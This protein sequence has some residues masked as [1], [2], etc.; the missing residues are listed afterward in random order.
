MPAITLPPRD[1]K[2]WSYAPSGELIGV[3]WYSK[4]IDPRLS[5][6]KLRLSERLKLL[7]D[8][9]DSAEFDQDARAFMRTNAD[10]TDRWW[11]MIRSTDDATGAMWFTTDTDPSGTWTQETALNFPVKIKDSMDTFLRV[12]GY[13]RLVA[14]QA[15]S[16]DLSMLNNGNAAVLNIS[17][18]TDATPIAI[19]T[20]VAHNLQTGDKVTVA[21]HTTNTNANGT[22]F[23]TRTG[24]S[25]FTL[26]GSTATGGGAG[27][28]TG[29]VTK[30]KWINSWW[31]GT[32]GQTALD[33]NHP[34]IVRRFNKILLIGNANYVHVI[35]PSADGTVTSSNNVAYKRLVFPDNYEVNWI[36]CTPTKA[37]I[38]L[39]DLIGGDAIAAPWNG[40][41]ETYEDPMKLLDRY[42]LA[43]CILDGI[44]HTVNG[45]GQLLV[46]NGASFQQVDALPCFYSSRRWTESAVGTLPAVLHRNGMTVIDGQIHMLIKPILDSSNNNILEEMPG[47]I[48]VYDKDHGLYCKYTLGQYRGTNNDWGSRTL[49]SV[50]AL[51]ETTIEKG[52]LLAGASIWLDGQITARPGII[53]S[54]VASTS[55]QRGHFVT[56]QMQGSEVSNFWTEL[57]SKFKRLE[58]STDVIIIKARTDIN[59]LTSFK[60]TNIT[61]TSTTTFTSTTADYANV[62]GGEEIEIM[63]GKG[64]GATAHVLSISV[65]AGTYTV[66]LDEAIPNVSGTARAAINNFQKLG[67]ITDQNINDRFFQILRDA[68]WVQIKIEMRGTVTSPEFDELTAKYQPSSF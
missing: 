38:G 46:Y 9:S 21:N 34:T 18:S 51:C 43:A 15:Q 65:L 24:A 62:S 25:T 11:A 17:S 4:N 67:S 48:W 36:V 31:I 44:P 56:V 7:Y 32:L 42:T 66:T 8:K 37:W 1:T 53:I 59:P 58:N 22:R 10:G 2:K 68:P 60:W 61:W 20:S 30:G 19:T 23:I 54:D 13:D 57:V 33:A 39:N 64:A 26:D 12:G 14:A 16:G 29:T 45:K 27:G 6:G 50:G 3:L 55:N 49:S 47:G 40:G 63:A 41:E 52:R 5:L 28:G 35:T